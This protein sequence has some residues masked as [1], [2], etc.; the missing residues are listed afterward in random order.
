[1]T[2]GVVSAIQLRIPKTHITV[3]FAQAAAEPNAK[4]LRSLKSLAV[5]KL[6]CITNMFSLGG[7]TEAQVR[8]GMRERYFKEWKKFLIPVL[9]DSPSKERK[10][11][12]WELFELDRYRGYS[13][14]GTEVVVSGEQEV[15]P[16]APPVM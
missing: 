15:L 5:V 7:E 8:R 9:K 12:R 3:A 1:M 6:E 4:Y 14:I 11:L 16:E 2:T 13:G 10:I